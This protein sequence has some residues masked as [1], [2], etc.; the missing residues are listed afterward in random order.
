MQRHPLE[1]VREQLLR[2]GIS[3]RHVRRF[4]LELHEHLADLV[5]RERA[6]GLTEDEAELKARTL[7]GTDN[8]LVRSMIER[9]APRSIMSRA[10]WAVLGIVPVLTLIVVVMLLNSWAM[11]ALFPYRALSGAAIPENIRAIGVA[12]T[13]LG[14]YVIGPALAAACIALSLRQRL[15]SR[16][17]W[18]SLALIALISGPLGVH[19]QFLS[20]EA[21]AV[22]VRG[23]ALPTVYEAGRINVA[24]TFAVIAAR[25]VV[26]FAASA[27]AYRLLKQ[28]IYSIA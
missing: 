28:R 21:G 17:V 26:L 12:L 2:A 10:P 9:G 16:W 3:P 13:I 22:G 7:L 1:N 23:S 15:A 19:I 11:T 5:A 25:A 4:V 27:L 18:V 14:S 8:Q 6:N 20:S 24:A